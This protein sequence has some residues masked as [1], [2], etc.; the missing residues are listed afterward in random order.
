[1]GPPSPRFL[2]RLTCAATATDA[3]RD[4]AWNLYK[5]SQRPSAVLRDAR[6]ARRAAKKEKDEQLADEATPAGPTTPPAD[7]DRPRTARKTVKDDAPPRSEESTP[8]SSDESSSDTSDDDDPPDDA[9]GFRVHPFGPL[10]PDASLAVPLEDG[11]MGRESHPEATSAVDPMLT[12]CALD[13]AYPDGLAHEGR[14]TH[15]IETAWKSGNRSWE[16][17]KFVPLEDEDRELLGI[18]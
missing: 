16:G 11:F 6:A 10:P 5:A 7:E 12:R 8:E 3:Q 15:D 2:P 4:E 17:W 9:T 18:E 1:M 14:S 13:P